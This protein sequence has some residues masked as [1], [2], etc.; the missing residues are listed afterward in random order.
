[1]KNVPELLNS[2]LYI[3]ICSKSAY[4]ITLHDNSFL[5][6]RRIY[7]SVVLNWQHCFVVDRLMDYIESVALKVGRPDSFL[8]GTIHLSRLKTEISATTLS[9][10]FYEILPCYT[11]K[12]QNVEINL[13]II[14]HISIVLYRISFFEFHSKLIRF[15]SC[16]D[17]NIERLAYW[18]IF[19]VVLNFLLF[20]IDFM[21]SEYVKKYT[22]ELY[23]VC[24]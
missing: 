21:K 8:L 17:Y 18:I 6:Q 20:A 1:M 5:K 4:V 9:P 23:L 7:F 15:K 2:L 3:A 22:L 24:L 13:N 19:Y 12:M 16:M 10:I 14:L 11:L